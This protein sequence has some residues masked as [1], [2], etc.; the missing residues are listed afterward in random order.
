M[1]FALF[2]ATGTIGS[3]ILNE[4]LARGHHVT[5]IS[6][7]PARLTVRHA[8]LTVVAAD[9]RDPAAVAKAVTGSAAV[10]SALSPGHDDPAGIVTLT[11]ALIAGLAQAKVRRFIMVGGAG[12]LEFAPGQ[13][14]I[15]A[16]FFPVAW[17]GIAQAHSDALAVLRTAD[18]DWTSFSPA[19]LIEPGTRT[20]VFRL[21]TDQLVSDAAGNSRISA[22][23]YA[24][25]LLDELEK[26]QFIRRRFTAAY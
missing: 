3:R 5:A 15:D 2:G 10:V 22:E 11:T 7:D 20:G 21:G 24:V 16:P 4:A 19:A 8:N 9:P 25:A 23:D 18:L 13:Q 14:L 17:K 6:R 12:S 1:K 26:P